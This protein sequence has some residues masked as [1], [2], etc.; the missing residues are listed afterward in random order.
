MSLKICLYGARLSKKSLED[1]RIQRKNNNK[2]EMMKPLIL[3][4]TPSWGDGQTLRRLRYTKN[5]VGKYL[6][7]D[8]SK[9]VL[10]IGQENEFAK[11]MATFFQ[12]N[13]YFT[14]SDLDYKLLIDT[15]ENQLNELVPFH[16]IFCFEVLEHLMN[17]LLFL[18]NLKPFIS[19]ETQIFVSVPRRPLFLWTETHFHE[20]SERRIKH[21]FRSAGYKIIAHEWHIAWHDPWFYV[22]GIR[23]FLRLT[24]GAC[25][26]H[27]YLLTLA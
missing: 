8:L 15:K 3:K 24:I 5:F 22:S 13:C 25:R 7:K 6:N 1:L 10:D 17:P 20:F 19:T 11:Q 14:T 27:L 16:Y 2:E 4:V 12:M 18:E 23:P 21:L 9:N 26:N